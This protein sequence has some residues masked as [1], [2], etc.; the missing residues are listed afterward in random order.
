M[1]ELGEIRKDIDAI[2]Q[3]ITALFEE[4]MKLTR[5]VAEYKIASGKPVLD[6]QREEQKLDV[7]AGQTHSEE[8]AQGIRELYE[9]IMAI[10]RR[11]Q[12]ALIKQTDLEQ[13]E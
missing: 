4:R 2:D 12:Q 6:P 5:Q 8:N 7:L 3:Q 9:L 11:Q 10:S 13:M 1:R